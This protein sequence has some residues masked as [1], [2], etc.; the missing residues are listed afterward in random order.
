MKRLVL[1]AGACAVVAVGA[2]GVVVA[3][4]APP[5]PEPAAH[6]F[7]I[8]RLDAIALKDG[9]GRM[10][11]NGKIFG[12]DEGVEKVTAVL[13]AAGL[14][15]DTLELSVN[16]LLVKAGSRVFV[17]DT[18]N[19]PAPRGRLADS[20][21]LAGVNPDSVTDVVISHGHGDHIGGLIDASGA[22]F[23]KNATIRMTEGEWAWLQTQT[24]AAKVVAAIKPKVQT[25]KPG[26][27][28][29]PG[30]QAVEVRGHTPGHTAALISD[31]NARLL[32]IGDTA[33]HYVVSVRQPEYTIQFD[34]DAPTA[35]V[36]RRALLKRAADEKLTVFAP[37]FPYPGLGTIRPEGDG[38][39]WVPAK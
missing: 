32:A 20:F 13:K 21:K 37:H 1:A 2:V 30:V 11:N 39:A 9:G 29:A 24:S 38:Y 10:P 28:L 3:Q 34:G 27:Q 6:K 7:K 14:P 8:G 4:T 19:G 16:A 23:F 12:I 31:G 5:P 26:A 35:E 17:F 36:S 18:G 33:H 25:F 22:L 15:T